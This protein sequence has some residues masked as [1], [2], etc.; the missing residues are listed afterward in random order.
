MH[1]TGRIGPITYEGSR[2][3]LCFARAQ[4]TLALMLPSLSWFVLVHTFHPTATPPRSFR[5]LAYAPDSLPTPIPPG[6]SDDP[7]RGP[8][9]PTHPPTRGR[10]RLS[11]A[12][13]PTRTSQP[14]RIDGRR[15]PPGTSRRSLYRRC[16]CQ[17][18]RRELQ[19]V[20]VLWEDP[21]LAASS[22]WA[23]GPLG[24]DRRGD[25]AFACHLSSSLSSFACLSYHPELDRPCPSHFDILMCPPRFN[26]THAHTK[27]TGIIL[28]PVYLPVRPLHPADAAAER[29]VCRQRKRMRDASGRRHPSPFTPLGHGSG[30]DGQEHRGAEGGAWQ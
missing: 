5:Q 8:G 25:D 12:P 15:G 24:R 29:G 10:R 20:F 17:R 14:P 30:G 26:R 21:P 7:S 16:G 9:E 18:S 19:C 22:A 1:S 6:R 23:G 27:C 28:G 3:S 2:H 13:P 4:T 11:G